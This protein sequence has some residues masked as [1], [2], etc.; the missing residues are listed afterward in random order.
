MNR[1]IGTYY[2]QYFK[3][4]LVYRNDLE[5][6]EKLIQSL[7]P[8]RYRLACGGVEYEHLA[9]IPSEIEAVE[10]LVIYTHNPCLRL[11]FARSWAELYS[12][13][14]ST[15]VNE[16]VREVSQIVT[17]T[18]R[19]LLWAFSKYSAWLAPLLGFGSLAVALGLIL[20]DLLPIKSLYLV[21][22]LLSLVSVWW[23]IGHRYSL[24]SFS[25]IELQRPRGRRPAPRD[26]SEKS[27]IFIA[28]TAA[29]MLTTW[30][31]GKFFELLP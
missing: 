10:V 27:L 17:E 8:K 25:R 5:A 2:S 24:H 31:L 6:I 29:G 28:G 21:S 22:W 11:K 18:E 3:M 13:E 12:G 20:L 23:I 1:T 30:L 14:D 16:A 19:P 4:P 26:R 7:H 15:E 9:D